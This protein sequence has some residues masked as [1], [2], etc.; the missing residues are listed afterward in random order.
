MPDGTAVCNHASV[1]SSGAFAADFRQ[2][3][4]FHAV[5]ED[6]SRVYWVDSQNSEHEGSGA[7]RWGAN[8]VGPMYLR[9]NAGQPQS[10]ISAGECTEP[11]MACTIPVSSEQTRFWAA[12]PSGDRA[13]YTTVGGGLY[14]FDLQTKSSQQ[15]AGGVEGLVGASEDLSRVYLVSSEDL[16]GAA[17]NSEGDSAVPGRWNLYL[18]TRGQGFAFVATLVSGDEHSTYEG[19]SPFA[20]RP[21]NRTSR[22]SPD[23]MHVAFT[24]R[25]R[26]TGYDNRDLVSGEADSEVYRYDAGTGKLACVS[27]NPSGA[28][29]KNG[30]SFAA[31]GN[32]TQT[33]VSGWIPGWGSQY[34]PS[35]FLSDDGS[36]VF[37]ESY[38]SLALTDTNGV[39]DVYEWEAEGAGDCS[40]ESSAFSDSAEGCISLISTG[41]SPAESE[42][43]E[44]SA[45]GRD[46][47]FT[48]D[49][50]LVSH[51]PGLIDIYDARAGGGV[52]PPPAPAAG[53]EGEACQGAPSPPNDPTPASESFQ[54]AGNVSET[55][56]K[57]RHC[58]KGKVRRRGR[59][60]SRHGK[61]SHKRAKHNRRAGR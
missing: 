36:R 53:C 46:V 5:S 9:E 19:V 52:P 30:R 1:G 32:G 34:Q 42:L 43:L 50:S 54:G 13:L 40:E 16:T 58:A 12:A 2:D 39:R 22:V 15:I 33:W 6:A 4:V 37:F 59:C 49:A 24:S 41:E 7:P 25:G 8:A 18:H 57:P 14:E 60:V 35:R 17:E 56:T 31:N 23:G 61:K 26:P 38:D 28:R 51:D 20:I 47:F 48:T 55:A 45:D 21:S 10:A 3:S 27:C 29:P 11:E 44:A